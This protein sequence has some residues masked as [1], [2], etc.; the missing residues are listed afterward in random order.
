[1]MKKGWCRNKSLVGLLTIAR[2]LLTP[3]A[4]PS[5]LTNVY[6][7]NFARNYPM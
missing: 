2:D 6:Y 7:L 3:I 4:L 5:P 1:L